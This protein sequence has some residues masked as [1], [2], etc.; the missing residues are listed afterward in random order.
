MQME[1]MQVKPDC[2]LAEKFKDNQSN[3]RLNQTEIVFL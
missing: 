1:V 3:E 2:H